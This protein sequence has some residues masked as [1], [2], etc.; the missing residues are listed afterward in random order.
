MSV[1]FSSSRLGVLWTTLHPFVFGLIGFEVSIW[2]YYEEFQEKAQILVTYSSRIKSSPWTQ[3]ENRVECHH[4]PGNW[5]WEKLRANET[6][7]KSQNE[8]VL[9]L[10][11]VLIREGS[12]LHV[13]VLLCVLRKLCSLNFSPDNSR[14]SPRLVCPRKFSVGM[15]SGDWIDRI[16]GWVS[17]KKQH[18]IINTSVWW[19]CFSIIFVK[20]T[21]ELFW[22]LHC[23][24]NGR[25]NS[26]SLQNFSE[27]NFLVI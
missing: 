8:Y 14:E 1:L 20:L 9:S 23:F 26:I 7:D 27:L 16:S 24:T 15:R 3:T 4:Q 6:C 11:C 13:L 2:T 12:L 21:Y 18:L 17:H 10:M 5:S 19:L 25:L 22:I